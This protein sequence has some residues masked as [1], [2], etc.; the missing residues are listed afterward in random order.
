M[1]AHRIKVNGFQIEGDEYMFA[2]LISVQTQNCSVCVFNKGFGHHPQADLD[3]AI[4]M[5]LI[6]PVYKADPFGIWKRKRPQIASK[7]SKAFVTGLRKSCE[8]SSQLKIHFLKKS[9]S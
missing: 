3:I 6:Y 4:W 1:T 5:Y 2:V 9:L 8:P 7:F